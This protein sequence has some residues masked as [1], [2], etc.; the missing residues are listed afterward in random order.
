MKISIVGAGP[1]RKDLLTL[2]AEKAIEEA[3][4]VI[5]ADR[6]IREYS[7][8]KTI[9]A[10][11]KPEEIAER[12][13]NTGVGKKVVILRSGDPGFFSSAGKLFRLFDGDESFK[14]AELNII[15]GISSMQYFLENLHLSWEN[16]KYVS[17]HGRK[18]N[19]I[20]HIRRNP[21]VFTLLSSGENLKE[22]SEKLIFYG[23]EKVKIIVGIRVSYPDEDVLV[24]DPSGFLS[25][26][27]KD[28]GRFSLTV[29]LFIN[30]N[31]V[32]DIYC[33]LEDEDLIRGEVPFTKR[34][35]RTL[36][37]SRLMLKPDS[38]L[39]DIGAGT[40][41]ISMEASR[42]LIDGEIYAI[43]KR[44]EAVELIQKNKRKFAADNV[45]VINDEAPEALRSLPKPTHVFIGG[46]GGRLKEIVDAC[47]SLN[48]EVKMVLN[49]ASLDSLSEINGMIRDKGMVAD[50]V[51][52]NV[53][54][55]KEVAGHK[56]MSALNPVYMI[57]LKNPEG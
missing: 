23:M 34:E 30:N 11:Y 15:P 6:L 29:A 17:L 14:G 35:V 24:T 33:P 46:S 16:I 28:P 22:I 20:G 40:G 53:S 43:E 44:S 3:D 31:P 5:G 51:L 32:D 25:E 26:Y 8:R 13:K 18:A 41:S 47:F 4:I 39:F 48:P 9:F 55:M 52:I 56:I 49:I 1:G 12:I 45:R 57:T 42:K 54:R 19:I 10:L 7:G 2:E 36:S 27:E 38:I 21:R 37:L 50:I